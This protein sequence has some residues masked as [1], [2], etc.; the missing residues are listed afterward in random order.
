MPVDSREKR[1][2]AY[3]LLV[4]ALI[5]GVD[6]STMDQSERQAAAWVYG[7]IAATSPGGGHPAMRRLGAVRHVRSAGVRGVSIFG[8]EQ[9]AHVLMALLQEA[10]Y[11]DR[12]PRRAAKRGGRGVAVPDPRDSSPPRRHRRGGTARSGLDV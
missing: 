4:P 1:M 8:S 11:A 10:L 3:A 6:P 12:Q 9:A 5:P 2:S 7:G